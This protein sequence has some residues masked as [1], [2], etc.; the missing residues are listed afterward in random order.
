MRILAAYILLLIPLAGGIQGQ[1]A[2]TEAASKQPTQAPQAGATKTPAQ[3]L[4]QSRG[5]VAVIVAGAD[6]SLKLGTGFFLRSSGLLLTNLHVVES[7][8]LAG[9]KLPKEGDILWAKS[10]RG[11]D[12]DNDL[13]VLEVELQSP[14]VRTLP[15]GDSDSVRAGEPIV[16]ISNPEGLEQTVSN[17]LI[18]GIR[19]LKGRKLFQITA[20]VSEGSS[21]APVFNERGEV[22]GVVV[23]S[24]ESGQN[25]NFAIPV[26]YAKP[27]L[28][29]SS[30][31]LISALP[32]VRETHDGGVQSSSLPKRV[33]IEER[34]KVIGA[35]N[36]HCDAYGN[37]Y[38]TSTAHVRN[39]SLEVTRGFMKHCPSVVSVTDNKDAADYS[40]RIA[41]GSSTLY[42]RTGDAV[43]VSPTRWRVSNLVK[44]VCGFLGGRK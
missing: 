33:Y 38:G 16:V 4:E 27:L 35:A 15:I 20:P 21:G 10:A 5:A 3:I 36:A 31:T 42:S 30:A 39:V 12:A 1:T 32:H 19:E 26:N 17:G 43:Y 22:I 34:L 7:S 23:A 6:K 2:L 40:L 18:S 44:D 37:C 41:A 8:Q 28:N 14:D 11:F 9:V 24:L 13:A 25:L 29:S